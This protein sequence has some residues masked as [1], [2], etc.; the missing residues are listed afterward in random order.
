MD[1][2]QELEIIKT[3]LN[4]AK[5]K[6]DEAKAEETY[7]LKQLENDFECTSLKEANELLELM[8]D[9]LT[10]LNESIE[11]QVKELK[12]KAQEAGLI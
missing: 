6:A 4:A 5:A 7:L 3:K 12:T 10:K 11:E 9:D 8:E 2:A 1:T